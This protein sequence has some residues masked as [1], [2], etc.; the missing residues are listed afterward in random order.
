MRATGWQDWALRCL[1]TTGVAS[2]TFL[3]GAAVIY[4]K[5]PTSELLDRAFTGGRAWSER[6]AAEAVLIDL[7]VPAAAVG[8][9]QPARTCDGY[10]AYTTDHGTQTVLINMRG[11]VVHRWASSFRDIWP[12]PTHVPAPVRDEHIYAFD[13]HVYPGGELL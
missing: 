13:A 12:S 10:T 4:F 7:V 6:Q 5:L 11:E 3:L 2:L 1:F 8:L 9:D